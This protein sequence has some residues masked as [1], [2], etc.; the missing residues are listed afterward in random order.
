VAW[1]GN[2][3]KETLGTLLVLTTAIGSGAAII[4]NRFFVL[5]VEPVIFTAIRAL[6]IGLAFFVLSK[7]F[8]KTSKPAP[9]L[10][11]LL[12]G[13][14]GGGLAFLLF[15]TG[16]PLTTG[17]RA[18]FIHKT[19]P[20]WASL[21]ALFFLRD[22]ISNK[23]RLAIG[24]ALLGLVALQYD[25]VPW[26][27]RTG[28]I[29]VL[30]ATILWA[31]ENTLAKGLM[32]LGETNWRVTFSRMFFG[33]LFLFGVAT[34]QGKLHLI[35]ELQPVQWLYIAVSTLLLTWYVLT[36]Y[37]GLKYINLSKASGILLLSPVISLVL[38]VVFLAEPVY[39]MQLVGSVLILLGCFTLAKTQ[40]EVTA[41]EFP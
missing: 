25:V 26:D 33:S 22:R 1:T 41:S 37:W 30:F 8:E 10:N 5:K 38:G 15:F 32:K 40:S 16:L 2:V 34:L 11:L 39:P 27:I 21:L 20:V 6:F 28:D 17:G 24:T 4:V 9:L 18:A 3:D 13:L 19:L 12:L 35:A 31:V 7:K 14:I 23:Q 29:L 36:W